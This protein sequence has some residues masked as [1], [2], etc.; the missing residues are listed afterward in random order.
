MDPNENL[1]RQRDCARRVMD[2][3][4][5]F[6]EVNPHLAEDLAALV[7][8]LDEW[9]TSGGFLPAAWEPPARP[10]PPARLPQ[11]I[12]PGDRVCLHSGKD[13]GTVERDAGVRVL[14]RWDSGS[15]GS[16][17]KNE[18][19]ILAPPVVPQDVAMDA[20]REFIDSE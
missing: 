3:M 6:G 16:W 9:I 19:R 2:E 17:H 20:D 13:T 1:K 11:N 4:T 10:H 5:Q 15:Y 8:S 18:L 14:V 12:A 7:V